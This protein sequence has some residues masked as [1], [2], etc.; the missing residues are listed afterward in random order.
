[1]STHTTRWRPIATAPKDAQILLLYRGH[2]QLPFVCQGCWVAVPHETPYMRQRR[3]DAGL[4][5]HH[6]S[7]LPDAKDYEGCWQVGYIATKGDHE[8]RFWCPE[9]FC[10]F[11]THWQ[12]LPAPPARLPRGYS[13]HG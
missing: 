10:V 13:R 11:P 2:D 5:T 4:E 8:A 3:Q 12:P 9:S 6:P 1:M 7:M